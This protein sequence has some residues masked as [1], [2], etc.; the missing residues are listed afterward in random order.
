[1][2]YRP[3]CV[4][5]IWP[6]AA[7]ILTLAYCALA[8][9]FSVHAQA[10]LAAERANDIIYQEN[11]RL[12]EEWIAMAIAQRFMIEDQLRNPLPKARPAF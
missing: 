6:L 8:V 11:K 4:S 10:D 9:Q 12:R 3:I 5:P 2:T 7:V 1:M